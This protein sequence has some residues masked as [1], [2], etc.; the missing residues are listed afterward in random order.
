MV[1][2]PAEAAAPEPILFSGPNAQRRALR[3]AYEAF[4]CARFFPF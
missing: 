2:A 1:E 3:Y 4:G